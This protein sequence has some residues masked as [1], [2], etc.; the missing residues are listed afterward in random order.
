MARLSVVLDSSRQ[1]GIQAGVELPAES[2]HLTRGE[3]LPEDQ[4]SERIEV[5]YLFLG[6]FQCMFS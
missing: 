3:K 4:E 2:V 6:D 5:I 1:P